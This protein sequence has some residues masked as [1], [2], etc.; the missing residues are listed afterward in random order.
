M[1]HIMGLMRHQMERGE[2]KLY[3]IN[4]NQILLD[5]KDQQV[6]IVGCAPGAK[7]ASYDCL[8]I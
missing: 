8:D 3:C 2:P 6:V 7:S 1:F 4:S 5:D